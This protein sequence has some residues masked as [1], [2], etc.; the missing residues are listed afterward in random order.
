MS[1]LVFDD[2]RPN[3]YDYPCERNWRRDYTE[4]RGILY[5]GHERPRQDSAVC[6]GFRTT[7]PARRLHGETCNRHGRDGE[8]PAQRGRKLQLKHE[9]RLKTVD[10]VFIEDFGNYHNLTVESRVKINCLFLAYAQRLQKTH[11]PR[12]RYDSRS[13]ARRY[14]NVGTCSAT[15]FALPQNH[16][17][18]HS[19]AISFY[20]IVCISVLLV[21]VLLLIVLK[22]CIMSLIKEHVQLALH[23]WF[24]VVSKR[25]QET[26][27]YAW[28][29][30]CG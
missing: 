14:T 22:L 5:V 24:F 23:V 17:K 4:I 1:S 27:V 8:L 12:H 3:V 25:C 16:R 7:L 30:S 9:E 10:S 13:K 20:Y 18:R 28:C 19:K 2:T 15:Q 21:Y 6:C 26:L 29:C 11:E